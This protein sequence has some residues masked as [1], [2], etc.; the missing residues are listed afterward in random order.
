MKYLL[1][2]T[3]LSVATL[4]YGQKSKITEAKALASAASL[5]AA[6]EKKAAELTKA[7][8]L[9]DAATVHE[10]TM[11]DSKAWLAKA[12]IYLEALAVPEL[13]NEKR[14]Q[15][16]NDALNKALSI[17]KNT[18]NN[19]EYVAPAVMAAFYN[20]ATG[21]EA[22]NNSNYD[23]AQQN[24]KNILTF[25]DTKPNARFTEAYPSIDT[26][27]AESQ[28]FYGKSLLNAGAHA[29]AMNAL[30]ASLSNPIVNQEKVIEDLILTAEKSG[31]KAKQLEYI[32]MGRTKFPKNT[33]ISNMELNYYMETKEYDKYT[34]KLIKAME[35]DPTN[36]EH[37]SNLGIVYSIQGAP[38]DG[39]LPPNAAEYEKKAEEAFL[40]A[41]ELAGDNA[42]Y[43]QSLGVLYYNSAVDAVAK[44]KNLQK[45]DAKD[46][47][48]SA[49][50]L[51]VR[52][53]Y[54][55]KALPILEKTTRLYEAQA[56]MTG[57]DKQLYATAL[58][59]LKKIY[60]TKN[61]TKEFTVVKDK[62]DNLK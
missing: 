12:Q 40:R 24:F 32:G 22:Y 23:G 21:I 27:R 44:A 14:L 48:K 31:N 61:K 41:L 29:E 36:P 10:K 56:S 60:A 16:A 54:Y 3:S 30:T 34:E 13:T 37:P 26:I 50:L 6:P 52:D 11:N 4:S 38:V 42:A 7:I 59:A 55:D 58:E 57:E 25:V 45:G 19:S 18:F 5:Q 49:Q 43:N 9:I 53:K 8:A 33:N 2:I 35:T 46:K 1:L 39:Y 47:A 62:L 28:Y 51:L 15:D 17:D 20:Y